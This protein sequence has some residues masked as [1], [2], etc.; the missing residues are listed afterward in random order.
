MSPRAALDYNRLS[1]MIILSVIFY[2]EILVY[3]NTFRSWPDV[4]KQRI[5]KILFVADP[6]IQGKTDMD[7]W[8]LG[9]I[10]RWDS[11]RY[12]SKTFSWAKYAYNPD[13][14]VFLGDL[15]DEG[16]VGTDEDF[17]GYVKRFHSIYDTKAVKIYVAGDN[18]IGGE[19]LDPVTANKVSRFK[20]S[21]PGQDNYFF[22]LNPDKVIQRTNLH[23]PDDKT[24]FP[25]V[26]VI[27]VNF[28]TFKS[29]QE[30]WYGLSTELEPNV[31]LRIVVSHIPILPTGSN[32]T[33]SKEVMKHLKPSVIF[34]AHDH[35][36]LDFSMGKADKKP[37]FGNVTI[38]TQ[39][40]NSDDDENE[41]VLKTINLQES[42]N[43]IHEIIVPTCSYRMGV[44]EMAFG[45]AQ[46]NFDTEEIGE[47]SYSNLWLPSRFPLLYVYLAAISIS[48]T[49]FLIGRVKKRSSSTPRRR[50]NS[51]LGSKFNYSKLV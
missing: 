19:G 37:A 48:G 9:I 18:D 12:L 30:S 33:F 7:N 28:L 4:E 26:E 45:L 35:R 5:F 36:G 29:S 14:I 49:L 42:D 41:P 32:P 22:Q 23:E 51:S 43:R 40:Q 10:T 15:M 34:S 24:K 50:R 11:D 27:P 21:F 1:L 44:K 25:I 20:Q 8:L 31:K 6:Q 47:V 3:F 16:S 13:V 38:F 46:I 17:R 39:K 2:N